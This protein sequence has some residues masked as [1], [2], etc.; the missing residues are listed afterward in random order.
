MGGRPKPLIPLAGKPLLQHV[1]ERLSPQ[2]SSLRLSVERH[3]PALEPFSLSQVPDPALGSN[4]PL[5]GLLAALT[6]LPSA[7]DWLLLAPC[8][9]P[10][11][12]TD[13][14]ACLLDAATRQQRAGAVARYHG[15]AQPTFSLWHRDLLTRLQRAVLH[16]GMGG[17]KQFLDVCPLP[18]VDWPEAEPPPFFNVN[19]PADLERA[20]NLH[21]AL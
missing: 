7:Q 20:E 12:P 6:D 2:V 17:F 14:G 16:E 11:L 15:E 18:A 21:A 10:F 5:G 4:G 9:A 13:L 1:I 19:T 3:D 8:D